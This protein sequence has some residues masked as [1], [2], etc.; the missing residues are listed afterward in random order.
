MIRHL[1]SFW[2]A[3][4]GGFG[5]LFDF[6]TY[7]KECHQ[8]EEMDEDLESIC[9][10][11]FIIY[12][13]IL[14]SFCK[15][16]ALT[17]EAVNDIVLKALRSRFFCD[18]YLPVKYY[19]HTEGDMDKFWPDNLISK[20]P[21]IDYCLSE[22]DMANYKSFDQYIA[23]FRD[24]KKVL[25]EEINFKLN[26]LSLSVESFEVIN[27]SFYKQHQIC[28]DIINDVLFCIKKYKDKSKTIERIKSIRKRSTYEQHVFEKKNH[29]PDIVQSIPF[30]L[31]TL[32]DQIQEYSEFISK[33]DLILCD[34]D[35]V[36]QKRERLVSMREIA[37]DIFGSEEIYSCD[38]KEIPSYMNDLEIYDIQ[39]QQ[40]DDMIS[41]LNDLD[42]KTNIL[43]GKI[44][45][46]EERSKSISK[47][48][49]IQETSSEAD[50]SQNK[51]KVMYDQYQFQID[52]CSNMLFRLNA[53]VKSTKEL[54]EEL[55]NLDLLSKED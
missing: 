53:L 39:L 43:K 6:V 10:F 52:K 40:C 38:N 1:I 42:E 22:Y 3:D 13:I 8:M 50:V 12:R 18:V 41:W 2:G 24:Y 55:K 48:N 16:K 19:Y 5:T 25:F 15:K 23:S 21:T 34:R 45:Q 28:V 30:F 20:A 51:M 7:Y 9:N 37:S 31:K 11:V 26:F 33:I 46:L 49:K 44:K 29:T 27:E 17:S 14:R 36:I 32:D 47:Q 54:E 35:K 4:V